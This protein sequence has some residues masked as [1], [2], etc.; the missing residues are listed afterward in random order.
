[1]ICKD[2][3]KTQKKSIQFLEAGHE[4]THK[5]GVRRVSRDFV[6]ALWAER[7]AAGNEVEWKSAARREKVL[8][9]ML[10]IERGATEFYPE[11][12]NSMYSF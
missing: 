11:I 4:A 5:C 2:G 7:S 10:H 9:S 12:T 3:T 6:D 1:M 8:H